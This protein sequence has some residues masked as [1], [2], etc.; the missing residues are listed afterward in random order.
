MN[1]L[2]RGSLGYY[3]S[4]VLKVV[5]NKRILLPRD[6]D[7]VHVLALELLRLSI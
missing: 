5:S 6:P 1:H 2:Y 4:P 7:F 3:D